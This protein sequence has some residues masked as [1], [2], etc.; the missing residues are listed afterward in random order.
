MTHLPLW[1]LGQIPHDICDQIINELSALPQR[2]ATMGV[3]GETQ[4][5]QQRSTSVVFASQDYWFSDTM[6]RF[7][8][9]ANKACCWDYLINSREAIQFAKYGA[10]QHYDWHID[11]FPLSGK[12][13]DRK[14]SVV[15]LLNDPTEFEGGQFQARLYQEYTV[16]LVKGSMIAFPSIVE[17]RVIP[18][19]A[20]FR[21]SATMWVHGPRFR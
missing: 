17:H 20:G 12:L 7:A 15:C 13:T 16:P 5:N 1:Y 19:T 6:E 18:V 11:T 2:D 3:D 10:N 9:E 14:V 8:F 4:D 21:Y